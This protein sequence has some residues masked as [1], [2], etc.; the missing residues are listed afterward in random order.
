MF[1]SVVSPMASVY[2]PYNVT[3][4]DD[5]MYFAHQFLFP[6]TDDDR[7]FIGAKWVE[8]VS[9]CLDKVMSVLGRSLGRASNAWW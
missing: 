8:F 7:V 1:H 6:N 4:P 9:V 3:S 2:P 5:Y